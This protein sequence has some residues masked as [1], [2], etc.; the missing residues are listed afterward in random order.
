[1]TF[2]MY[3][4]MIEASSVPFTTC[5]VLRSHNYIANRVTHTTIIIYTLCSEAPLQTTIR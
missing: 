5:D 2:M 4:V 3:S 1:M